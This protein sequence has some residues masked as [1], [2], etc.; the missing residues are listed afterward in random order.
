MSLGSICA[1]PK[2]PEL[3]PLSPAIFTP[4]SITHANFNIIIKLNKSGIVFALLCPKLF[5]SLCK[6]RTP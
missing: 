3:H 6:E 2:Q 4:S 1:P 5:T